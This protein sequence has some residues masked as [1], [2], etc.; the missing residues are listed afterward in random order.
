ML[1]GAGGFIS[2]AIYTS[3]THTDDRFCSHTTKYNKKL[4]SV[5]TNR[6]TYKH[7][8]HIL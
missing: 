7:K 4:G 6:T 8:I 5:I 3:N 1:S 2:I